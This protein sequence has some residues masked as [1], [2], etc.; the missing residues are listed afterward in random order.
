MSGAE[1]HWAPM[2]TKTRPSAV[3]PALEMLG[4]TTTLAALRLWHQVLGLFERQPVAW[5]LA[6]HTVGAKVTLMLT[7]SPQTASWTTVA[8]EQKYKLAS[9]HTPN[10]SVV[11]LATQTRK[12][13][14]S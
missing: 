13:Y 9:K 5:N 12:F 10:P 14:F 2:Y 7:E 8:A 4:T 3:A 11:I 6:R 1:V